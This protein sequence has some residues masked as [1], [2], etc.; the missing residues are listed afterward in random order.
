[1]VLLDLDKLEKGGPKKRVANVNT[2]NAVLFTH[3][4]PCFEGTRWWTHAKSAAKT[5]DGRAAWF[6]LELNLQTNNAMDQADIKI[7]ADIHR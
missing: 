2:D 3:L 7:K 6:A 4:K 1:M 5:K